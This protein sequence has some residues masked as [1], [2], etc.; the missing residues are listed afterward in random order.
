MSDDSSLL[1]TLEPSKFLI[2]QTNM[3]VYEYVKNKHSPLLLVSALKIF[4]KLYAIEK[5]PYTYVHW[6]FKGS[7][8]DKSIITVCSFH[9]LHWGNKH[10]LCPSAGTVKW[11][12]YLLIPII[13][14]IL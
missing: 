12:M 10:W 7:G 2:M 6:L 5:E 4:I 13:I 9:Q 14:Y 3:C 8:I 1:K 11:G